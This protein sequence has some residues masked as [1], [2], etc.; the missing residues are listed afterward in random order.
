[1][2]S[3][4]ATQAPAAAT[5]EEAVMQEEEKQEVEESKEKEDAEPA[6]IA[7]D[8]TWK[9]NSQESSFQPFYEF[10][11]LGILLLSTSR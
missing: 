9:S 7:P 3:S 11:S 6:W 2:S 10:H 1:M 8:S 5:N 4:S